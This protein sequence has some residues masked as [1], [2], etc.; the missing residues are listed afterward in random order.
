MCASG[1]QGF[2]EHLQCARPCSGNRGF[3]GGPDA[4]LILRDLR[5]LV[6]GLNVNHTEICSTGKSGVL[7][8]QEVGDKRIDAGT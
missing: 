1:E 3:N 4:A 2:S 8:C 7:G 5:V 6:R